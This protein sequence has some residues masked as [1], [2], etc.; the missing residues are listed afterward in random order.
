M[1]AEGPL[2]PCHTRTATTMN[3][4]SA[5]ANPTITGAA[6]GHLLG[7]FPARAR[8]EPM[9]RQTRSRKAWFDTKTTT[10]MGRRPARARLGHAAGLARATTGLTARGVRGPAGRGATHTRTATA[11]AVM[12]RKRSMVSSGRRRVPVMRTIIRLAAASLRH[13]RGTA[14]ATTACTTVTAGWAPTQ[15]VRAH[16]DAVAT[17]MGRQTRSLRAARDTRAAHRAAPAAPLA[18]TTSLRRAA[19]RGR[20]V[21]AA[22]ETGATGAVGPEATRGASRVV[23]VAAPARA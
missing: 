18:T 16:Q 17:G 7:G 2:G 5:S 14:H 4:T 3:V 19:D 9:G 1:L 13:R 20:A 8:Q 12:V 22:T 23:A 21:A 6:R 15:R 11:G 10:R